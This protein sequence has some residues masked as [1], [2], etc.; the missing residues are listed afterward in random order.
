MDI[1]MP[2]DDD[3]PICICEDFYNAVHPT[4]CRMCNM[5]TDDKDLLMAEPIEQAMEEAA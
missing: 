1:D 3:Q 4:Y 5:W 2:D